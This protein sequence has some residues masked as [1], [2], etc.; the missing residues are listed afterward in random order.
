MKETPWGCS[1][2]ERKLCPLGDDPAVILCAGWDGFRALSHSSGENPQGTRERG[3]A[4]RHLLLVAR[5]WTDVGVGLW[6]PL[7][8]ATCGQSP[9]HCAGSEGVGAGCLRAE[10]PLQVLAS[11]TYRIPCVLPPCLLKTLL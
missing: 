1:P 4:Q 3:T 2:A 6:V 9:S 10:T 8:T 11:R 5:T 7:P